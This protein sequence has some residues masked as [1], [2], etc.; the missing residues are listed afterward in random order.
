MRTNQALLDRA[1]NA[2]VG[3]N[4]AASERLQGLIDDYEQ[5]DQMSCA[6]LVY[7]ADKPARVRE[8]VMSRVAHWSM[9]RADVE[10]ALERY[11][12]KNT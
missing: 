4:A 3:L 10:R 9:K 5:A 1:R 2:L 6:P 12:R 8:Q 11:L 7:L